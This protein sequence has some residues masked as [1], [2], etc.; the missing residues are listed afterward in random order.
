MAVQGADIYRIFRR[1]LGDEDSPYSTP[2]LSVLKYLDYGLD[3]LAEN[4]DFLK[5]EDITISASDISAGYKEPTSK[6]VNVLDCNMAG[7]DQYWQIRNGRL[8][9]FDTDNIVAGTYEFKYRAYY[10]RFDGSVRSNDYFDYPRQFD[11][12]V[13]FFALSLYVLEGGVVNK[14]G[15]T[16]NIKRLS[17]EGASI[18]YGTPSNISELNFTY[19]GLQNA[20]KK[21]VASAPEGRIGFFTVK[22]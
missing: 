3:K 8:E 22:I 1:I 9:F 5:N 6:I 12:A 20:A 10:K 21:I 2:D 14:N 11:L 7:R 4:T 15:V 17:E 18:E 19:E 13:V 16:K